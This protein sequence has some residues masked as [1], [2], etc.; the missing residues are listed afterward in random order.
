LEYLRY[1]V[2]TLLRC[3]VSFFAHQNPPLT[4]LV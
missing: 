2:D 4:S 3:G 1:K